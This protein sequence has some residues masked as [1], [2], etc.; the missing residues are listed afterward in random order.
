MARQP[1][2]S[3]LVIAAV[4]VA[5]LV[6]GF[7][8]LRKHRG[9][10]AAETPPQATQITGADAS[11]AIAVSADAIDP[12]N[13][14]RRV[15][16][17]GDLVAKSPATDS[18]LGITAPDAIMLLRFVEMLQWQEHCVGT[19]CT[20]REVWSPQLI[21][22]AKFREAAEHQNPARLPM[23]TARFSSSDVRLGAF[24]VDAATLGNYRLEA[25]L[26]IK[27]TPI[28][29]SVSQ[30]PSN[31]APT[32]R[33]FNGA[34]YAGDPEHRK[35]GDVRVSYRIIPATKVDVVG[36]QRGDKL[37]VQKSSAPGAEPM[38]VQPPAPA[39]AKGGG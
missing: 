7:L 31:L 35:V 2:R 18:Q 37:V 1:S 17:S 6:L 28:R 38:F 5:A 30:L 20:Y 9:E 23:T 22:S 33:D 8:W 19:S 27:P 34:L 36:I 10:P 3:Q 4:V 29:V 11:D 14:G 26:R 32:F 24:R 39:P 25:S 15:S 13:E 12:A 21:R 16:V